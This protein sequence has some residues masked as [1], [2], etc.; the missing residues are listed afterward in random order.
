MSIPASIPVFSIVGQIGHQRAFGSNQYG[1]WTTLNVWLPAS[2]RGQDGP[3]VD[4]L[5]DVA[6]AWASATFE[7]RISWKPVVRRLKLTLY[8]AFSAIN[9]RRIFSGQ[10][11]ITSYS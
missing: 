10:T 4:A 5:R 1:A 2:R 9:M 11:I 7:E 3:C 6:D 8:G